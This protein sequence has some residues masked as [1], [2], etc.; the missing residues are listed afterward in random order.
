MG[1]ERAAYGLRKSV[2][3]VDHNWRT[4]LFPACCCAWFRKGQL[5]P[6]AVS[7]VEE[8]ASRT[9]LAERWP[10]FEPIRTFWPSLFSHVVSDRMQLLERS[11]RRSQ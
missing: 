1:M 7:N 11:K 3:R 8:R 4:C 5:P 10:T 6:C 2:Q 9:R